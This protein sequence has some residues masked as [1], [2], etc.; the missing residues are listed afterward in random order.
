MRRATLSGE[1]LCECTSAS[2]FP[3]SAFDSPAFDDDIRLVF[4]C[5]GRA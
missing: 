1:Q 5:P 4:R 3:Q 2:G